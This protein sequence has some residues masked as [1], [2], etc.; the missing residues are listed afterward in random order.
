MNT[1]AR[2]HAR[3]LQLCLTLCHSMDR[4][5][6]GSS[7][8]GI[9]QARILER[10]A[11]P[12]SKESSQPRNRTYISCI[13]GGF[14]TADPWGKPSE[15][16]SSHRSFH[17]EECQPLQR[18]GSWARGW[19]T[20]PAVSYCPLRQSSQSQVLDLLKKMIHLSLQRMPT[21]HVQK[22]SFFTS[23]P[24]DVIITSCNVS[25]YD[26]PGLVDLEVW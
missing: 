15:D 1:R 17:P 9:L 13:A 18:K 5:P 22:I 10:V 11:M 12:S 2:M 14:F 19:D 20:E 8:H 4:I 23:I 16:I 25:N 7:V 24:E 26:L 3:S 21:P 6:P